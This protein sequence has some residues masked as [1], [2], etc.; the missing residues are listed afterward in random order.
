M[1]SHGGCWAESRT[2]GPA[3]TGGVGQVCW[4][5]DQG[6]GALAALGRAGVRGRWR[7]GGP[8]VGGAHPHQLLSDVVLCF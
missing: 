5:R 6:D 1:A 2:K 4:R 8:P 7:R 3:A